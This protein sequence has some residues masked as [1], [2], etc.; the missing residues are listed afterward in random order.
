M[1]FSSF[2]G[3]DKPTPEPVPQTSSQNALAS[4]QLQLAIIALSKIPFEK[5]VSQSNNGSTLSDSE[6]ECIQNVFKKYVE[7][8]GFIAKRVLRKAK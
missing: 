6:K 5:C 1:D 8:K 2:F 3:G 4:A 7:A